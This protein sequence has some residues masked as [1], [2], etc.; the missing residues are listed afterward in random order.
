MRAGAL[1]AGLNAICKRTPLTE[2][3]IQVDPTFAG[4][5]MP[6]WYPAAAELSEAVRLGGSI[7]LDFHTIPYPGDPARWPK[8]E[9]SQRRRRPRGVL[10][11]RARDAD[12]RLFCQADAPIRQETPN[13]AMLRLV[14]YGKAPTEKVPKEL[15]FDRRFTVY[16]HLAKLAAQ[17]IDFIPLRRRHA[18]LIEHM[19]N[20][21]QSAWRPIRLTNRGRAYRTPRIADETVQLRGYPRP[22]R[23]IIVKGLG[24]DQPTGLITN[25]MKQSAAQLV[26]RY[27]R[28]MIMEN[29]LSEAIDFFHM[30]VLSSAVPMRINVDGPRT[31]MASVLYRLL[32][33]RVGEGYEKVESRP[34]YR[35][36][37]RH[38]GTVTL[39]DDEIRVRLRARS[40][41]HYL[42]SAGFPERRQRIP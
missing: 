9:V 13:E 29:V 7:D 41:T 34:I 26:D 33:A 32:G 24:H 28:R 4:P 6:R 25:Q 35:D 38:S 10:T 19:D 3:S 42:V 23:Q 20:L 37:V 39:A 14:D 15:V 21:D 31:V 11:V 12:A 22:L 8:P 1:F 18:S 40:Q 16:A 27:A 5:L 36:R 17:G 30:D 2:Y